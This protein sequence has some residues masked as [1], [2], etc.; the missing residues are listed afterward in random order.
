MFAKRRSRN[1]DKGEREKDRRT[2]GSRKRPG[3]RVAMKGKSGDGAGGNMGG[4][5]LYREAKGKNKEREQTRSSSSLR[6]PRSLTSASPRSHVRDA[7]LIN[8]A[9][10]SVPSPAPKALTAENRKASC[11]TKMPPVLHGARDKNLKALAPSIPRHGLLFVCKLMVLAPR[12]TSLSFLRGL[13]F[14]VIPLINI[15]L[16]VRQ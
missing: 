9:E 14:T 15:G 3:V 2:R 8:D 16:S 10:L 5:Q 1:G 13:F 7:S 6:R 12:C 11:N 4:K